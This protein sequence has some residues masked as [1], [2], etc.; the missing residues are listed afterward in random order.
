MLFVGAG[1]NGEAASCVRSGR[2]AT[3]IRPVRGKIGLDALSVAVVLAGLLAAQGEG[4]PTSPID[5]FEGVQPSWRV[6]H[7]RSSMG[8]K[9]H[10]R[11]DY[12]AHSGRR[13]EYIAVFGKRGGERILATHPI[14]PS[15]AINE[16]RI[17]LWIRG[18]RPG[19]QLM[20][21]VRLPRTR[22]ANGEPASFYVYGDTYTDVGSWQEL[23]V[24]E[25]EQRVSESARVERIAR[26]KR[27][28]HAEAYVDQIAV[29]LFGGAG[30]NRVWLD[31]L[32]L[33]A[34][35]MA[36]PPKRDHAL[37]TAS[38]ELPI[39]AAETPSRRVGWIARAITHHGEPF[40]LLKEIGFNTIWL[41]EVATE[42][43]LDAARQ[44]GIW[45]ICPP[46]SYAAG[47]A[48]FDRVV[49]WSFDAE[50][51]GVERA[52]ER[53]S[54]IR[55][56]DMA[57]RPVVGIA[58]R[59]QSSSDE[60]LDIVVTPSPH[61]L[62]HPTSS[63]AS[64]GT[65][66]VSTSRWLPLRQQLRKAITD[67]SQGFLLQTATSLASTDA[68]HAR[69]V[70]ELMNNEVKMLRP[71][72]AEGSPMRIESQHTNP[73]SRGGLRGLSNR[74]SDIA[75]VEP[76]SFRSEL[77]SENE[78]E[79]PSS[80]HR[81]VFRME[82][83]GLSPVDSRRVP[84]G[85]CVSL[86]PDKPDGILLIT[87]R[88]SIIEAT[89]RYLGRIGPRTNKLLVDVIRAELLELDRRLQHSVENATLRSH[90]RQEVHGLHDRIAPL[91]DGGAAN[92]VSFRQLDH[93]LG[94]LERVHQKIR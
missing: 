29:N 64:L 36:I 56:S 27:V 72:I 50:P 75:F 90:W 89:A 45:L 42:E 13:S 69:N 4:A 81:A 2:R 24:G 44:L 10:S 38:A 11:T 67:G 5:D 52:V 18:T 79:I 46:P 70:A 15:A 37:V 94:Q 57:S 6:S 3:A 84:G 34:A 80:H 59:E 8:T 14:P 30:L 53:I 19:Y 77:G 60:I 82:P 58:C 43:Q 66:L 73:R 33:D 31:D 68:V 62:S 1:A 76:G 40:D 26:G 48:R 85:I 35:V 20:A 23:V 55:Q 61:C 9:S 92:I 63:W 54:E 86:G 41:T 71:W 88:P 7:S 32:S 47:F 21:R 28:D 17:S 51:S 91:L 65:P 87:D 16:L 25:F 74:H 39:S 78:L 93:V 83:G 22:D 49:A 12:A